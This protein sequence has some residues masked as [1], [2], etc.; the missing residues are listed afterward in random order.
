MSSS[1]SV[2][3]CVCRHG[4]SLSAS[5]P[6]IPLQPCGCCVDKGSVGEGC[7]AF[8]GKSESTDNVPWLIMSCAMVMTFSVSSP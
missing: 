4:V 8:I 2:C 3:M 1:I 7:K 5:A 6:S